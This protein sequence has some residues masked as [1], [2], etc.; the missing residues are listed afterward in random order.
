MAEMIKIVYK[1]LIFYII[2]I[3][4]RNCQEKINIDFNEDE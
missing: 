3:Q 4:F 2:M 1:L